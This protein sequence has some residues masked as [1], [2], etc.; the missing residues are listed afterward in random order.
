MNRRLPFQLGQF[1][2]LLLTYTAYQTESDGFLMCL[3]IWDD[4]VEFLQ[5]QTQAAMPALNNEASTSTEHFIGPTVDLVD[6]LV[7]RIM[8]GTNAAVLTTL[9]AEDPIDASSGTTL[10]S[11][12]TRSLE[13]TMSDLMTFQ[14]RCLNLISGVLSLF[15]QQAVARLGPKLMAILGKIGQVQ[16]AIGSRSGS[17][18]L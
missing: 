10:S 14:T 6:Q 11:T 1:L 16:A 5:I 9:D 2:S 4:L 3:D 12:E 18:S 17:V 8:F 15:P 13:E 7:D